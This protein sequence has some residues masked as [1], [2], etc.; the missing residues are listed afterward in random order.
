MTLRAMII[1]STLLFSTPLFAQ[2]KT[3]AIIMKNGDRFKGEIKAL[4]GGVL[5]V[6]LPYVD[7]TI[8]VQW[9]QVAQLESDRLFLVHTESGAVYTG[10]ISTTGTSND[11][12]IK[13]ELVDE[14]G[15][16]MAGKEVEIAQRKIIKLN[17]TA[18]G[19]W[20]RFDGAI[21]TGS[22]YSKGNESFQYN[23]SSQV[24]YT[25]ERWSSN[26]NFNSSL[27]TNSGAS[28]TTR[29]QIDL[30]LERLMRWNNWF[31]AG[32]T[33][34]LQ[35]QVQ[36][37]NLQ[38]TLGLGVGR[39]LKNTNRQTITLLGGLGWQNVNYGQNVS[40]QEGQNTAVAFVASQIKLFKFKKTNLDFTASLLPAISDPGRVH[41]NTNAVYYLKIVGDLS[42]NSSFYGSWDTRPPANFPKS[43][44]GTSS[45]LSWTFGNR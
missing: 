45:G 6:D 9:S 5:S 29:N 21:N 22:L 27:S 2:G 28:T 31:Y 20:R 7:G 35:S 41:F 11:P 25:R 4:G 42:W 3:D 14:K 17:Q 19:F 44:Y 36:E 10:K 43:D 39:Y 13:I 32:T 37:I 34:F 30:N 8:S 33:S 15:K 40:A 12:P 38:T 23:V 24:A 1:C 26:F 18:T 16:E